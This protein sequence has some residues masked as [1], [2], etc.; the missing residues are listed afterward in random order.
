MN[1]R[2]LSF[3]PGFSSMAG[4]NSPGRLLLS[5]FPRMSRLRSRL[6]DSRVRDDA[7]SLRERQNWIRSAVLTICTVMVGR[8]SPSRKPASLCFALCRTRAAQCSYRNSTGDTCELHLPACRFSNIC[9]LPIFSNAV[10]TRD[11][12][13]TKRFSPCS[14]PQSGSSSRRK[15][16]T[17]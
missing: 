8:C 1:K 11:G 14:R 16:I 4:S 17:G 9:N 10:S 5:R 13:A 6:A 2:R 7:G 3:L 15:A 12:D